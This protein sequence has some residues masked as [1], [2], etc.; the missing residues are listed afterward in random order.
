MAQYLVGLHAVGFQLHPGG[1]CRLLRLVLLPLYAA[2]PEEQFS[3]NWFLWF[4]DV[5]TLLCFAL[6]W[7]EQTDVEC[8]R[9]KGD[10]T[11]MHG[12]MYI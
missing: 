6:L 3:S 10:V 4:G 2:A 1:L 11:N 5:L 12:C 7:L 9:S 8:R